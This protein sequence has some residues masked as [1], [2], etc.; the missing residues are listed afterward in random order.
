MHKTLGGGCGG[1][2]GENCPATEGNQLKVLRIVKEAGG[3]RR[4]IGEVLQAEG[5]NDCD[6]CLAEVAEKQYDK[7]LA[8]FKMLKA[9][10]IDT[11][12]I[13]KD[14]DDLI[15][16]LCANEGLL[17]ELSS[18]G[19]CEIIRNPHSEDSLLIFLKGGDGYAYSEIQRDEGGLSVADLPGKIHIDFFHAK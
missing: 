6:S 9:R 3:D 13:F 14:G 19:D 12:D 7:K 17:E 2:C 4:V 8:Q 10:G 5:I 11:T 15:A 1:E 18:A 16:A